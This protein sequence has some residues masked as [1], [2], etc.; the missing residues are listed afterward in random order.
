MAHGI[1]AKLLSGF[2]AVLVLTAVVGGINIVNLS[3]VNALS[4]SM[5]AD[6]V[7]PIRDLAQV[8][9]VLGDIDSQ[10]QRAI[11]DPADKNQAAYLAYAVTSDNDAAEMDK[12]IRTYRAASLNDEEKKRLGTYTTV[13]LE[14][15]T[16]FRGVLKLAG[17]GD[18]RGA[19]S[20]YFDKAAAQ[21]LSVDTA[22]ASL[23]DV[24][25]SVA[26]SASDQIAETSTRDFYVTLLLLAATLFLGAVVAFFLARGLATPLQQMAAAANGIAQGDLDQ[27]LS[28]D[29]KD[30]VGL[31]VS[32]LRRAIAYLRGMAEVAD[33]MA[34]GDLSC[35]VVPKTSKDVLGV[36]FATMITNLRELVGEVQRSAVS[37]ADTSA[38][39]GNAA[40]ET[41]SAVQQV[42]MAVQN[43]ATGAQETSRSAQATT[44]AVSQLSQVIDG[45]ARG[46]TDQARQVQTTSATATEMAAG[47]EEVAANAT[48]VA[49][50]SQQT[51]IAAEHGGQAVRETTAA[52]AQI[53]TVVGQAANKVRE[54]GT[55][56]Q[57]IGAVVET[58]DDIAEQTN[59]LAL[60]AAI[61]AARAGEHGRGFAVVA[62]EVRK[63]AERSG[64]ETKQIAELI[65]QVQTGT[66][67]A[68]AAMDGGAATVELGSAKAAQAGQALEEI[69]KAVQETVHQVNEI[70][71]SSQ[72]MASGARSVTDSMHSISAVVEESSAATEQMAAQAGSVSGA[73]QSIAAVSEEQSAA[74]EQVSASTQQMSAQ[75]EQMSA[76][77]QEL[78]STAEQL[79]DLVARFKLD[80]SSP[81]AELSKPAARSVA[82]KGAPLRR[83]A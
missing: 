5:Y 55:L 22:L 10:I 62:D 59:L 18:T 75:V 83:V 66:R 44:A 38:Q 57:K 20:L 42:T 43:V 50:A 53:Q 23:I 39:L 74:T 24:N 41:G 29:R 52:M 63:L 70:A 13:W 34:D 33:A 51:R 40:A 27:D 35:T 12:L 17:A 46:A 28:L 49:T 82:K 11:T 4:G 47:I 26:K 6:R 65:A 48:H 81:A 71:S 80:D 72:Q 1:R 77:A 19:V 31:A 54:L 16:S 56:G 67:E 25:D 69:L 3:N 15:Q 73:I 30:E 7:V 36:A 58:I 14:Y 45:I 2:G 61:E 21:Y 9:A 37:L 79:R 32:A 60:N 76:Q 78:A 8:R 64:R 68:V